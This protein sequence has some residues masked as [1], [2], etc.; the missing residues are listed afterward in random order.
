MPISMFYISILKSWITKPKIQSKKGINIK[1]VILCL[2]KTL[3]FQTFFNLVTCI[4]L[5]CYADRVSEMRVMGL[6]M[7]DGLASLAVLTTCKMNTYHAPLLNMHHIDGKGGKEKPAIWVYYEGRIQ[8]P[9]RA[10]DLARV[11]KLNSAPATWGDH[12]YW[13][14]GGLKLFKL[15]FW[16]EKWVK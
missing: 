13:G 14:G 10:T 9:P 8:S 16:W 6:N 4:W 3:L 5:C 12:P 15:F 2:K 1:F 11:I 7:A